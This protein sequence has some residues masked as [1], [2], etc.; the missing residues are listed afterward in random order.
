MSKKS[1]FVVLAVVLMG[2]GGVKKAAPQA[3]DPAVPQSGTSESE[4]RFAHPGSNLDPRIVMA[5]AVS[6]EMPADQPALGESTLGGKALVDGNSIVF[7]NVIRWEP[8]QNLFLVWNADAL[9]SPVVD[10]YFSYHRMTAADQLHSPG[11][12]VNLGSDGAGRWFISLKAAVD[13]SLNEIES[14]DSHTFDIELHLQNGSVV[15][16]SVSMRFLTVPADLQVASLS[17]PDVPSDPSVFLAQFNQSGRVIERKKYS[18]VSNRPVALWFRGRSDQLSLFTGLRENYWVANSRN[19]AIDPA[20]SDSKRETPAALTLLVEKDQKPLDVRLSPLHWTKVILGP[21]EE[22]SVSWKIAPQE[23]LPIC[24]I[25]LDRSLYLTIY[26]CTDNCGNKLHIVP[27][28]VRVSGMQF[29]GA[30]SKTVLVTDAEIQE[31]DLE[32]YA[33]Q[34]EGALVLQ[35]LSDSFYR[36][37][38][39]NMGLNSCVGLVQ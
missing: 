8:S 20:A 27:D 25:P 4:N 12:R 9:G 34:S 32:F 17:L 37:P 5:S 15:S 19:D 24:N 18:N 11:K 10:G 33:S 1:T 38:D 13:L 26:E 14:S 28:Q 3:A 31:S 29:G 22:V 16:V 6:P 2:C 23:N 35:S 7:Q 36:A 30:I 39:P 21:S